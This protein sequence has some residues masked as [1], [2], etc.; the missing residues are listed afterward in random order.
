MFTSLITDVLSEY[1]DFFTTARQFGTQEVE[2]NF[3]GYAKKE[4]N[5]HFKG[6]TLVVHGTNEDRGEKLRTVLI[7][8][9]LKPEDVAIKYS[10]G[11]IT[12]SI[13]PKEEEQK[14]IPIK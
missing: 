6:N 2:L 11:L 3:A 10:N 9:R 1:P 13:K 12:V 14:E 5:A 7:D 4:I 8:R